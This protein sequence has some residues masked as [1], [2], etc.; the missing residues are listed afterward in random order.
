MGAIIG[1]NC[2]KRERKLTEI[3]TIKKENSTNYKSTE[4]KS[5]FN[6]EAEKPKVGFSLLLQYFNKTIL[7]QN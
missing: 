1:Q 7:V 2:V 4:T 6:K 5:S 3:V